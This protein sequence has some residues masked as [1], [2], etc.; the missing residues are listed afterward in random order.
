MDTRS[1]LVMKG[2]KLLSYSNAKDTAP[3]MPTMDQI[4]PHIIVVESRVFENIVIVEASSGNPPKDTG[5]EWVNVIDLQ[6]VLDI[7]TADRIGRGLL[8]A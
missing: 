4:K 3:G 1:A 6:S 8:C 7:E 5:F 2:G